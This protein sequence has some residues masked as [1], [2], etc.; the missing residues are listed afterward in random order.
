VSHDC[1]QVDA[2]R[3]WFLHA[4][5]NVRS[6]QARNRRSIEY[7]ILAAS[8]PDTSSKLRRK[9]ALED[10]GDIGEMSGKGTNLVRIA[11]ESPKTDAMTANT[12]GV[13]QLERSQSGSSVP[14]LS[15]II[16][17]SLLLLFL[18]LLLLLLLL[19]R[20]RRRQEK[21]AKSYGNATAVSVANGNVA[22]VNTK[23]IG[24][25]ASEV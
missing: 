19:C 20:R 10:V 18:F 15:V 23:Y 12:D 14:Q 22:V 25:D 11:T 4:I 21:E 2:G 13:T 16:V 8:P 6:P 3:Q 7:N 17:I 9:R 5:Y 1:L 24:K